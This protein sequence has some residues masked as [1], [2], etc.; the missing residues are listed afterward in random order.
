MPRAER[1]ADKA[2]LE[3]V[4][5][6]S[7]DELVAIQT[8]RLGKTLQYVYEN[9]PFYKARFDQHHVRPEDF[10]ELT[11]LANFPSTTKQ[12]LRDAY[13][14][15]MLAVPR[16]EL[17]RVHASSGTTG[18]PTVVG[19]TTNDL[20]VWSAVMQ[21]SIRAAGGRPTDLIH[22]AYGYG[23]FTGGLG[24]HDGA[25]RMGCTV[26]PVSGGMTERQ[27]TLIQDFGAQ[28]ISATPSYMLAI[29]D[30][31]DRQGV[32][33]KGTRL[34]VGLFGAEPW[35]EGMRQEIEERFDIHAVNIY[36]LSEIIGPG[37]AAECVETK[38]G[39]TVWEDHFYPE[40][41]DPDSMQPVPD[42]IQ[43]E[44][45]FTT[46]T[47]TG[48]PLIR[49][50]TRDLTTLLP[51]TARSMRRIDRIAGR[52]DDMMII[53][54]VN[55]FPS[56][57]EEQILKV[58]GLSPHYMLELTRAGQLDA[59]KVIVE[60]RGDA[61]ADATRAAAAAALSERIKSVIGISSEVEVTVPDGIERSMGKAVRLRD[62]R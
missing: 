37:V 36:G 14:F 57:I 59:L 12:H 40:I 17:V 32:D 46:I 29:A 55:V 8:R 11:D 6:A 19:Y 23:L 61:A 35:T 45:L 7:R 24:L 20:D 28:L 15:G 56:Q 3:S 26:V 60:A 22:N 4:E 9:V 2:T 41:V 34:E 1:A 16:E 50:R 42:G 13:P 30:E 54:G 31:F 25:Q 53:R 51:P 58:D 38:D 48:M 43:G 18:K 62:L 27:V 10:S 47:K 52:T 21:R 44:L 5:T 49:Y 39:L 33:P